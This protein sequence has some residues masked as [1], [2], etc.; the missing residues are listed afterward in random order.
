MV[1]VGWRLMGSLVGC[2]A[3]RSVVAGWWR[4]CGVGLCFVGVGFLWAVGLWGR[5]VVVV[6]GRVCGWWL[7]V[8]M[9]GHLCFAV[10]VLG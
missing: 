1:A 10:P 4:D 2:W 9:C 3:V 8:W 7:G 6:V 5:L